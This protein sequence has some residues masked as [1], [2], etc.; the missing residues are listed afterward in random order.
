M[1]RVELRKFLDEEQAA[2]RKWREEAEKALKETEVTFDD[3]HE[4]VLSVG[5]SNL[6]EED[7]GIYREL[8]ELLSDARKDVEFFKGVEEGINTITIRLRD[9]LAREEL[10]NVGRWVPKVI[11]P[12]RR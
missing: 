12:R 1:D 7:K 11:K 6:S 10:A 9:R 2:A 3:F 5:K 8:K 4:Y